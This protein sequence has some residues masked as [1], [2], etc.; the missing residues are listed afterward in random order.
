MQLRIFHGHTD[1]RV[2][3]CVHVIYKIKATL[4]CLI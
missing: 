3:V 4:S 1:V 2:C